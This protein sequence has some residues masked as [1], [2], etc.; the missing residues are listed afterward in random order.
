MNKLDFHLVQGL[1]AP[2]VF[3]RLPPDTEASLDRLPETL[4]RA[5]AAV[6]FAY[7]AESSAEIIR[8][9]AQDE[10]PMRE[11]YL[12][13]SLGEFVSM[14]GTARRDFSALGL[15]ASP[16]M[17]RDSHSPLLHALRELRNVNFHLATSG[18]RE[19]SKPVTWHFDGQDH[20]LDYS[21]TLVDGFTLDQFM[22][23]QNA[24]YYDPDDVRRIVDWFAREQKEW[25]VPH[26]IVLAV[27]QYADTLIAQLQRAA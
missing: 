25:G 17:I 20:H 19:D 7:L 5:N 8:V 11:A 26:L 4:K 9:R 6:R 21:L 3:V 23:S 24:K 16:P 1:P 15:Q 14:E 13:A 2:G 27:G 12:R 18:I 22:A 10:I